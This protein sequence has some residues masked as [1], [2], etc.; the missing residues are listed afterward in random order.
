MGSGQEYPGILSCQSRITLSQRM[1]QDFS[2]GD[3]GRDDI[4]VA[5]LHRFKERSNQGKV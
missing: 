1:D 4:N 5:M 2:Q 3:R